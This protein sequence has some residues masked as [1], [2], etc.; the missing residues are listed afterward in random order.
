[1]RFLVFMIPGVYQPKHG[2]KTDAH[3]RPDMEMVAKMGRFNEELKRPVR[4]SRWM[5]CSR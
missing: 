4:C 5:A 3:F 1:M 2:K